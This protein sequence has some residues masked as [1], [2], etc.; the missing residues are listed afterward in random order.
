VGTDL[1][2]AGATL[3]GFSF[4]ITGE[5]F[6]FLFRALQQDGRLELLSRP[7]I[8][9]ED[10]QEAHISIG[11]KVPFVGN[12]NILSDGRT[13]TIVEY[14]DVGIILDVTPHINPDGYVTLEIKPEISS[15]S[16]SSVQITEGVFA[17]VFNKREAETTV[18]VKQGETI[19]IGGLITS[20]EEHRENKVPILGDIPLLGELFKAQVTQKEKTELLIVLTPVVV[21][22]ERELRE[23]SERERDKD[24]LMP[25][26]MRRSPLMENLRVGPEDDLLAPEAFQEERPLDTDLREEIPA[27]PSRYGPA[28]PRYG[29]SKPSLISQR[30]DTAP[31]K[32]IGADAYE[33][34]LE[35]RR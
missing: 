27:A 35:L 13:Q 7:M 2:A 19:V 31:K 12:V 32:M 30:E 34:Y 5:D 26:S 25:D 22:N 20:Q 9:A 11:Q 28:K 8:L 33:N 14:E 10:N 18:T 6:N 17:P 16:D 21:Q 29:P 24:D 4:T 23:L 3:G 1:G 15:L